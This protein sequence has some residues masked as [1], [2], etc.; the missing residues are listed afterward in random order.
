MTVIS[1]AIKMK[2][3]KKIEKKTDK[4]ICPQSKEQF[5]RQP[6]S[7]PNATKFLSIA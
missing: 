3:K 7:K 4:T 2:K 6:K 1:V 5:S